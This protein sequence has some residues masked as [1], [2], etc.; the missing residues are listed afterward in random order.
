MIMSTAEPLPPTRLCSPSPRRRLSPS[1]DTL[2]H[3]LL[4]Q[5]FTPA[6]VGPR[7]ANAPR[8]PA[9]DQDPEAPLHLS[10]VSIPICRILLPFARHNAYH[11]IRLSGGLKGLERFGATVRSPDEAEGSGT[12]AWIGEMV[13]EV[14]VQ[15]SRHQRRR[16]VAA[17]DYDIDMRAVTAAFDALTDVE[18]LDLTLSGAEWARLVSPSVDNDV[19][20]SSASNRPGGVALT[21]RL[22]RDDDIPVGLVTLARLEA[23]GGIRELRVLGRLPHKVCI[24]GFGG[25]VTPPLANADGPTWRG[26]ESLELTC[27]PHTTGAL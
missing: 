9:D 21:V 25:A 15:P 17:E 19:L 18:Q 24:D 5:I 3:E 4:A 7:P 12:S 23:C 8:P 26:L 16:V 11:R 22:D 6:V 20:A 1:L 14:Q 27:E 2:P 13:R 10:P